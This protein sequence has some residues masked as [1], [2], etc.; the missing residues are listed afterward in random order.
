MSTIEIVTSGKKKFAS[1]F[2]SYSSEVLS[3]V[4]PFIYVFSY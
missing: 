2:R 1:E 4:H 3:D